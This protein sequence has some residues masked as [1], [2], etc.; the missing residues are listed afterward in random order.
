MH[1]VVASEKM[2]MVSELIEGKSIVDGETYV[3]DGK[4]WAHYY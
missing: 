4:T 3:R 1:I 2:Y